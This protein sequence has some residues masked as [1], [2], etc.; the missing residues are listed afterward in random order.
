MKRKIILLTLI[1]L[2]ASCGNGKP[3]DPTPTPTPDP[4]I[5]DKEYGP[6]DETYYYLT[7]NIDYHGHFTVT[8]S[9][10]FKTITETYS[11]GSRCITKLNDKYNFDIFEYYYD[12]EDH[13]L[14]TGYTKDEY[15]SDGLLICETDYS[16]DDG[17][18]IPTYS[19]VRDYDELGRKTHVLASYIDND[20]GL[21]E[22]EYEYEYRYDENVSYELYYYHEDGLKEFQN[23]YKTIEEINETTN[24]LLSTEYYTE[25]E[26]LT[27]FEF[28]YSET[29]DLKTGLI[30]R[31]DYI[32]GENVPCSC[33]YTYND[34]GDLLKCSDEGCNLTRISEYVYDE[35]GF[36]TTSYYST[37]ENSSKE[38]LNKRTD[39]YT[40][41]DNGVV[42]GT[43][44]VQEY[45]GVVQEVDDYTY[46]NIGANYYLPIGEY[47]LFARFPGH[48]VI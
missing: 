15:N 44:M 46:E 11:D 38:V 17:K 12:E 32:E 45:Y 42:I 10:D 22:P 26:D 30:K 27:D 33:L 14:L 5:K 34:K 4:V 8:Y 37:V 16:F 29:Y 20:T 21:L 25:N 48:Y 7:K 36:L 40:T 2:L 35:K 23:C 13:T 47:M 6:C 43:H 3:V 19:C 28:S 24:E 18:M 31:Y 39:T 9:E 41:D 1:P